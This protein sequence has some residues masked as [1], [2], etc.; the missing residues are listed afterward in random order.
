MAP[1]SC[2]ACPPW[3]SSGTAGP[4]PTS[5]ALW[6]A[7]RPGVHLDERGQ[8]QAAAV[9]ARLAAVPLA[10]DRHQPARAL[11]GDGRRDRCR[12]RTAGQ[13]R[14][15]AARPSRTTTRWGECRY[16]DWTGQPLQHARQGPALEGRA[17]PRQRGDVPRA[18]E[19]LRAMQARAV[20]AVRGTGTPRS[21][22]TTATAPS[23]SRCSHGD[24]I[25]ALLADALGMHLDQ[26][27]R[28]VGRPGSVTRRPL[29]RAAAV[30]GAG[31]R[32]RR[33][34][35]RPGAP[36]EARGGAGEAGDAAVGRGGAAVGGGAGAT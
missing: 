13:G 4:P 22:P 6:P 17:E 32:H 27:Q 15:P 7:G 5:R 19:S 20:D 36:A 1:R 24:V 30:R 3:C 23:G 25:K 16:G 18:G 21:R 26:F 9:A 14:A 34:P 31:Q 8:E 29:H 28:I 33:R 12:R 2:R 10:A 11:P 35:G